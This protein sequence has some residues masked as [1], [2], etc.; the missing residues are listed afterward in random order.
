MTQKKE[1]LT[2]LDA[3]RAVGALSVCFYHSANIFGVSHVMPHGYLAVDLFFILSGFLSMYR[4]DASKALNV[5]SFSIKR[6]CRIYPIYILGTIF[7]AGL[8]LYRIQYYHSWGQKGDDFIMASFLGLL[9]IPDLKADNLVTNGPIFPFSVPNW[10]IFW[11]LVISIGFVA[12]A[13]LGA[14]FAPLFWLLSLIGLYFVAKDGAL[15]DYGYNNKTF[16]GGGL[17]ASLGLFTGIITAVLYKK[18]QPNQKII[19]PIGFLLLIAFTLYAIF[20]V[21]GILLVE[22]FFAM[23]GFP[24]MIMAFAKSQSFVFSNKFSQTLG[25]MS[26]AVFGIH[27]GLLNLALTIIR[28]YNI[29]GSLLVGSIWFVCVIIISFIVNKYYEHQA[30]KF[31]LNIFAPKKELKE[32]IA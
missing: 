9:S 30:S 20:N 28:N 19:E 7:G 14:K 6:M 5:L 4:F 11:E 27:F 22:F 26:F 32:K 3:L 13:K 15:L 24:F 10:T 12:W 29:K 25:K 16:L 23:L 8:L 17:R 18:F 31:L 2:S 1:H 21:K